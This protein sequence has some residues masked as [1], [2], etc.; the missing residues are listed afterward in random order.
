MSKSRAGQGKHSQPTQTSGISRL[1]AFLAHDATS[2]FPLWEQTSGQGQ[3]WEAGAIFLTF[4][5]DPLS[6]DL[7]KFALE[8][9]ADGAYGE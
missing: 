9:L 3:I 2:R 5:S 6:D 4:V 1:I 7:P 8:N